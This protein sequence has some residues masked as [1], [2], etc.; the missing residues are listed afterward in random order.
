MCQ[1]LSALVFCTPDVREPL[2]VFAAYFDKKNKENKISTNKLGFIYI[3]KKKL[4]KGSIL[5]LSLVILTLY[6]HS[7]IRLSAALNDSSEAPY[8]SA[9]QGVF[10]I[11]SVSSYEKH[12]RQTVLEMPIPWCSTTA[13][14]NATMAV[15]GSF[16]WSVPCGVK[17]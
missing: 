12:L 11:V 7:I 5:I 2:L 14:L 10:E 3:K 15:L 1:P 6:S 9:Q 17:N 8:F 4:S 13:N 16:Q